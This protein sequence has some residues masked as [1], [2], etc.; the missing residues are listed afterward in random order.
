MYQQNVVFAAEIHDFGIEF[1]CADAAHRVGGQAH[2]HQ[3]GRTGNFLGNGGNIRQEMV[4]F[5]QAIVPGLG[6]AQHTAGHEDRVAGVGQQHHVAVVA[7]R[8]TQMADAVLAAGKTHHLVGGDGIHA[9]AALV[10]GADGVQQFRQIAQ[11]V[12]PVFVLFGGFDERL[13][14]MGCRGKIRRAHAQ[15]I[16]MTALGLQRNLF[17]VECGKDLGTE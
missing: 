7:K 4:F 16:Q 13:L 12:F 17:V 14:D 6:A 8:Q 5:G 3:L 10:V 2:Q 11:T 1:R 15:V 9:E